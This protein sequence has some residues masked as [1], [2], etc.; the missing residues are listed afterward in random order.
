MA[1]WIDERARAQRQAP[2]TTHGC[3]HRVSPGI[4]RIVERAATD[5]AQFKKARAIVRIRLPK[6]IDHAELAGQMTTRR[7]LARRELIGCSC[8]RLRRFIRLMFW[9]TNRR[10]IRR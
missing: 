5:D 2:D 7:R 8:N 1:R 9:R 10:G 4:G 3:A 6:Y